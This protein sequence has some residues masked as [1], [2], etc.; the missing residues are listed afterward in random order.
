[1]ADIKRFALRLPGPE[2]EALKMLSSTT[3]QSMNDIVVRAV[4]EHLSGSGRMEEFEAFFGN[5]TGR[6]QAVLDKLGDS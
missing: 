5:F 3:G 4:R 2:H 1:M 6:Y